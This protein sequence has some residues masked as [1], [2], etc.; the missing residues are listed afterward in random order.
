MIFSF[1]SG[2]IIVLLLVGIVLLAF[3]RFD[4][5]NRSLEQVKKAADQQKKMIA[6]FISTRSAYLNDLI[7]NIDDKEKTNRQVLAQAENVRTEIIKLTEGLEDQMTRI[8]DQDSALKGLDDFASRVDENLK[9][10]K[11]E[12]Q[13]IDKVGSRLREVRSKISEFEERDKTLFEELRRSVHEEFSTDLS[14]IQSSIG[15]TDRQ[16]A[17][18]KDTMENLNAKQDEVVRDNLSRFCDELELIE[19]KF[20][21]RLEKV[22]D[23]GKRLESDVFLALNEKL[24]SRA[25]SLEDDWLGKVNTL[26]D[27]VSASVS[28]MQNE[29]LDTRHEMDE[30]GEQ[31]QSVMASITSDLSEMKKRVLQSSQELDGQIKEHLHSSSAKITT[32]VTELDSRM[33][34]NVDRIENTLAQCDENVQSMSE[35]LKAELGEHTQSVMASITSDLGEMQKRVL[36]SSQELDGQIKAHLHSSS[37]RIT[38]EVTELDS[39]MQT[40]VDRIENTLAQ[41]DENVQSM[42]ER[43][44]TDLKKQEGLHQSHI[45]NLNN[46]MVELKGRV[47]TFVDSRENEI[48][49]AIEVRQNAYRKEADRRFEKIEGVITEMDTLDQSLRASQQKLMDDVKNDFQKFQLEMQERWNRDKDSLD[50]DITHIRQEMKD[51]EHGLEQIK[52]NAYE[53]M[54]VKIR[55]VEDE[56]FA[57][58]KNRSD[59]MQFALNDW[60]KNTE[61]KI[62]EIGLKASNERDIVERRY[63]TELKQKYSQFQAQVLSQFDSVQDQIDGFKNT[64]SQRMHNSEE[65]I[66][67]FRHDLSSQITV[68][69]DAALV[70]FNKAFDGFD[71]ETEKKFAKASNTI[72]QK[73]SGFAQ[74]IDENRKTLIGEFHSIQRKMTKWIEQLGSQMTEVERDSADRI[75]SMKFD[76]ATKMSELRDEY[77]DQTNQLISESTEER[78]MMKRNMEEIGET[79]DQLG[80]E[81]IESSKETED[82]LKD[83]SEALLMEFKQ[84]SRE[85]REEVE[86]KVK[87]LRQSVQDS[88]NRA[89]A[90]RKEIMTYMDSEHNRLM[91]ELAEIEGRQNELIEGMKVFEKAEELK[92]NIKTDIEGLDRRLETVGTIKEE[93]QG[94]NSQYERVM[95]LYE[96]AHEKIAS[97]LE[98]QQKVDSLD[99]KIFRINSLSEAV[100][101]KL[102]RMNDTNDSLQELQARLKKLENLHEDLEKQYDRL[103]NKAVV[104]DTTTEGIDKSFQQMIKVEEQVK[105]LGE[106]LTPLKEGI[107]TAE[108]L[109]NRLLVN[110]EKIGTVINQ[111][112]SL[113][114]TIEGLDDRMGKMGKVRE[115]LAQSETRLQKINEEI[116]HHL[117]LYNSLSTRIKQRKQGSPDMDTREIVVK[118]ARQGWKTEEIARTAK[119]SQ[120]EVELILELLPSEE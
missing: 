55:G 106:Q 23:E 9:R 18:Y 88:R 52:E 49:E 66:A 25:T 102:D 109:Q 54:S 61:L 12:S 71:D 44:K 89:D 103:S 29:L 117:N 19:E 116:R 26:K 70:E 95:T 115:W 16:V 99:A 10:L 8:K 21:Q 68:E 93:M 119:L 14:S 42:S 3:R 15:E 98:E 110:T 112:D 81:L 96:K 73:L 84:N 45:E 13:Y 50:I 48:A 43:L 97:F 7:R 111:V 62:N 120:G 46:S 53:N 28:S 32:E 37:A 105:E 94:V 57:N 56:F 59:Q 17:L 67:S 108:E 60:E 77:T 40:N 113:E 38:T 31:T 1:D 58:L 22:A 91:G 79:I 27:E 5:T 36:Q 101:L 24:E 85:T 69:K 51:L 11:E 75:E 114:T 90:H 72:S 76:C 80:N 47:M 104:I 30:W 6:D 78:S 83:Q 86:R 107:E 33:Q 4:K 20:R 118:L 82:R 64:L 34:T 87:E 100:D 41:C 35:R 39:R 74:Q 2:N 65:E 92:N 63:S